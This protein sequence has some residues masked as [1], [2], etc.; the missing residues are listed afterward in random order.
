MV[1]T[2]ESMED[3]LE[4]VHHQFLPSLYMPT[5]P[6]IKSQI[7]SPPKPALALMIYLTNRI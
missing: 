5:A 1:P 3:S 7:L 2:E 4:G 6:H